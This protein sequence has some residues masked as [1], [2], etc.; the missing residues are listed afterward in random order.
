MFIILTLFTICVDSSSSKSCVICLLYS[1]FALKILSLSLVFNIFAMVY[2]TVGLLHLF[3]L[4]FIELLECIMFFVR[5][6][7]CPAI[8]SLNVFSAPFFFQYSYRS[9]IGALNG[10]P[11]FS[12]ALFISPYCFFLCS[13]D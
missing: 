6:G 8:I 10:V 11:H 5:F 1:K 12:E 2:L 7:K 9:C 13:L 4:E 3:Y